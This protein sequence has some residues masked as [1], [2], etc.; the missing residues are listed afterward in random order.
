LKLKSFFYKALL[1]YLVEGKKFVSLYFL[2]SFIRNYFLSPRLR[3]TK[4]LYWSAKAGLAPLVQTH[5]R[6]GRASRQ[7][8][9]TFAPDYVKEKM[10]NPRG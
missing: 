7:K 1:D 2:T 6:M 3:W 4:S 8:E 9:L 10:F 5:K